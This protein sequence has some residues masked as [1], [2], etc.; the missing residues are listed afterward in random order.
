MAHLREWRQ[1]VETV[2]R[3]TIITAV[4]IITAGLL[5]LIWMAFRGA[6]NG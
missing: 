5:A 4:G 6:G 3:Q 2:K 1:S